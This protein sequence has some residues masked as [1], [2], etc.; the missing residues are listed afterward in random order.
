MKD[1]SRVM[2]GGYCIGCGACPFVDPSISMVMD[3]DG[4][5]QAKPGASEPS[6]K[7]NA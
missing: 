6:D 3:D 4:K 7:A 2:E 1:I 5:Y